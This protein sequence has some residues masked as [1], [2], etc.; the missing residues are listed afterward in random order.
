MMKKIKEK[1]IVLEHW[2][3]RWMLH[4]PYMGLFLMVVGMPVFVLLAVAA[5]TML[6]MLPVS[7][8]MGWI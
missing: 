3:E 2:A 1:E 8:F 7:C 6:I 5:S 4:H